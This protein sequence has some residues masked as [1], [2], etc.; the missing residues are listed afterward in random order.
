MNAGRVLL[1]DDEESVRS[2]LREY[3]TEFGYEVTTAED[4]QDALKQFKS[5][6]FECVISDMM[7]PR[8]DGL[9]LLN[10]IR[11]QDKRVP[12]LMI[13]GYPS[14][15]S[16]VNAIKEGAY[17]YITKPFHMDDIRLKLERAIGVRKKEE[18]LQR[19]T[20]LFWALIISI[21]VWLVLGVV[22]GV[23]WK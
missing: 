23:I 4:G 11:V 22:L 19:M 16:A 2:V 17:D 9:E 21:P 14:I 1:V 5:G 10:M 20:G 12:F 7:M 6:T 18:A 13:T 15:D 8:M 3:L